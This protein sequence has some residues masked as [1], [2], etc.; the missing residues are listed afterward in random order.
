MHHRQPGVTFSFPRPP[1]RLLVEST[2][3][4]LHRPHGRL[5]SDAGAPTATGYMLTVACPCGV[6]FIRL[7]TPDEAALDLAMLHLRSG[8]QG[9]AMLV[10]EDAVQLRPEETEFLD[11]LIDHRQLSLRSNSLGRRP[12]ACPS[13]NAAV[14]AE[15]SP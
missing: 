3:V 6:T 9:H 10:A 14:S 15:R 12:P 11:P 1:G 4:N 2:I 13:S 7:L 8:N 5:I